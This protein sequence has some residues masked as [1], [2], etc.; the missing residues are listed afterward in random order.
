MPI[1]IEQVTTPS[2]QDRQDLQKIYQDYPFPLGEELDNWLDQQ[3]AKQHLWAGRFN[4]RL[5]VAA[6]LAGNGH[7]ME[8]DHL[9][10]RKLTR[11]RGTA[12]QFLTL[13]ARLQDHALSINTSVTPEVLEPLL[14]Q[15][16]F[17]QQAD[18]LWKK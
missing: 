15:N 2:A 1:V 18:F 10:V 11:R 6:T 4:D 3:I 16:G 5:L 13:L 14:E 17:Q 9:C 7:T 12:S 8:L